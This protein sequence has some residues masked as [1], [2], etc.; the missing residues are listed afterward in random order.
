[1]VLLSRNSTNTLTKYISK[2][3][4]GDFYF[5]SSLTNLE[6]SKLDLACMLAA[7]VDGVP[8]HQ[9]TPPTNAAGGGGAG[10]QGRSQKFV[11]MSAQR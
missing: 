4:S 3:H 6:R 5:I 7:Q 9:K 10:V 8:C 2:H 1:M 11:R